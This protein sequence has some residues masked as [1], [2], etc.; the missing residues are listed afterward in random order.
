MFEFRSAKRD[1][2]EFAALSELRLSA[3]ETSA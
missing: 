3:V 2:N 1:L